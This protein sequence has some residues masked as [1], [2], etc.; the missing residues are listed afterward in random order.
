MLF[1]ILMTNMLY[2]G[3]C[4]EE[5]VDYPAMD[6]GLVQ[7]T[8]WTAADCQILCQQN[9][10]CQYWTYQYPA[11]CYL[12]RGKSGVIARVTGAFHNFPLTSGPKYCQCKLSR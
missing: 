11:L 6:I 7:Y 8:V 4:F 12:K 9:S 10:E 5:E 2:L 3:V 1:Q